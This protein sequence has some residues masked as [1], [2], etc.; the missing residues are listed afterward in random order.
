[1]QYIKTKHLAIRAVIF[2]VFWTMAVFVVKP[3]YIKTVIYNICL[4]EFVYS[5]S[6]EY[7][8]IVY[9]LMQKISNENS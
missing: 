6:T 8:S 9:F 4:Y 2:C 7:F 1:M 3:L 5:L